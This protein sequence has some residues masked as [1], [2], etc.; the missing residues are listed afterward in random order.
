MAK[1]PIATEADRRSEIPLVAYE[2]AQAGEPVMLIAAFAEPGGHVVVHAEIWPVRFDGP[3][4]AVPSA[5]R[6][7]NLAAATKFIDEAVV[8]MEYLGCTVAVGS[9]DGDGRA[10]VEADRVGVS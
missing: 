10:P 2:L 7:G 3:G 1:I 5:Y 4:E 9:S 6:F 8:A